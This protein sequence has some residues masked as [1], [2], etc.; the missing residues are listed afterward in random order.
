MKH[1]AITYLLGISTIVLAAVAYKQHR[2]NGRL[3]S[4]LGEL[5]SRIGKYEERDGNSFVVERISKQMEDIAYQQMDISNKR[6]EEALFQMNVADE[7]RSRAE[8]EQH[9]AQEF[10]RSAMEARNMA[11]QQRELAVGLQLKAE[12]SRNVA[13]TLSY[14]ALGRSLASLSSTQYIAGNRD[15]SSLLA[16]A[17]WK[18]TKDY[19]GNVDI[20]VILKS[21]TQNSGSYASSAI[22]KGGVSRIKPLANGEGIISVS[23]YGDICQWS[24]DNGKWQSKMLDANPLYSYRDVCL[25]DEGVVYALAYDGHLQTVVNGI[26]GTPIALPETSGFSRIVSFSRNKLLLASAR[27]LHF[28]DTKQRKVTMTVD[29]P[30][31]ITAIG[32]KDGTYIVFG[33]KGKSWTIDDEGTLTT[34]EIL[35]KGIVTA[36][37]WS[38]ENNV[39][40]VGTES[41]DIYI[42]DEQGYS[43]GKMVGHL[44]RITDIEFS[45]SKVY[46]ASYD[47]SVKLWDITAIQREPVSLN[48]YSTWVYCL[49][50]P[51]TKSLFVGDESGTVSRIVVS[52]DEMAQQIHLALK[53]DFTPEEWAYYVG[54]NVPRTILKSN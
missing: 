19:N 28:F 49:Y 42:I 10:A 44:S 14:L 13:D 6:R 22:H 38:K 25:D 23:R 26:V 16:Y 52:P 39:A 32:E 5:R 54:D 34:N 43:R 47:H 37:R 8:S 46:S 31:E 12:H 20:P 18:F 3:L 29:V 24:Y 33:N 48:E 45:G 51:D 53:R 7:M 50:M 11:E 1:R 40:A 4:E 36:Y 27:H 2:D 35:V 15:A 21:L 30:Q 9:K 17:A 41:G